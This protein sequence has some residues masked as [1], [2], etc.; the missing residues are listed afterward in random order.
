MAL[1]LLRKRSGVRIWRI[2]RSNEWWKRA[3][4]GIYGGDWWRQNLRMSRDTFEI[5]CTELKPYLERQVTS[6]REPISVEIRVA[7]TLWRLATNVEYRT[8]AG[9]FGLGRSTVG[10]IV[11]DTCEVITRMLTHKYV[12]IPQGNSLQE[13]I[14]GF[15]GRTGFPQV[16]GAIDG[17][18]IPILRPQHSASDYYNRKGFYSIIMQAVVDFRGLFMDVNIGW[19][20]KVHDARVFANSSFFKKG[21]NGTLFPNWKHT[22]GNVDVPLLILGDPAYPLLMKPYLENVHTT[23]QEQNF[24]H[25]Q[26]RARMVV[27]NAFGRLKGR[28]RCLLKR[29]DSHISNVPYIVGACVVLHNMCEIYGDHCLLEWIQASNSH[30]QPSMISTQPPPTN[31]TVNIAARNIRDAI[32]DFL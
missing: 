31:N 10:E 17:T 9:L 15:E 6:F 29:N 22:I 23:P 11:L 25:R 18:H 8:I 5:L 2:A 19:P 21:S 7:V 24:N 13:V 26:S 12:R 4:A 27:E 1:L 32:R 16:V 28:W 3:M 30:S 14:D 20:G